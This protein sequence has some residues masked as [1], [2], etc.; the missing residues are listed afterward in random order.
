M[1]DDLVRNMQSRSAELRSLN[2]RVRFVLGA[3]D[4]IILLD[5]RST[6]VT[7]TRADGE[8]ECTLRLSPENLGKLMDGRLNPMLAYTMGKLK[9][10]GSTGIAMKLASLLDS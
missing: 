4:A 7:V 6:P 9:V 10:E 5:A 3:P 2:A 8:A 1:V